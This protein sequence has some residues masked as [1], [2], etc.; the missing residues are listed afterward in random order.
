VANKYCT[1]FENLVFVKKYLFQLPG[2]LLIL[3][4]LIKDIGVIDWLSPLL[5]S[6]YSRHC[7]YQLESEFHCGRVMGIQMNAFRK[8]ESQAKPVGIF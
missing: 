6:V 7:L 8:F 2:V 4:I 1:E 5:L 3:T